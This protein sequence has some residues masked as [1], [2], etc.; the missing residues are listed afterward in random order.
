MDPNFRVGS[1]P[2][3]THFT[4]RDVDPPSA[5]Y[6]LR[7]DQLLIQAVSIDTGFAH[8]VT[9]NYRFLRVPEVQGG[10][11][12]DLAQ[13]GAARSV[14][15]YGIIDTGADVLVLPV[16]VSQA[17]FTRTLG[18]G[19]MLAVG[20]VA[21]GV[22]ER[23]MIFVRAVIQ[24]GGVAT[25]N[26]TQT[27][28]S[29]YVVPP[30]PASWPG[31]RQ[32][33]P[34]EGPGWLHLVQVANPG[35]GA[36]WSMAVPFNIRRRILSVNAQLATSATVANRIVEMRHLSGLNI[37]ANGTPNQVVVA[38]ATVQVTGTSSLLTAV[39][40]VADVLVS[41]PS[42]LILQPGQSFNS[43]TINIQA[44]DQWSNIFLWVED[45]VAGL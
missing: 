26:A 20:A 23:G 30:T 29:D 3:F 6:V 14:I 9:F 41:I 22:V 5:L 31:G 42:T 11:P 8:N 12:S 35:A 21:T 39:A 45:W 16:G 10:Q 37:L 2:A 25:L 4:F 28:F 7:D 27:L 38:G 44:G 24:R 1:V 40:N 32:Q 36:D 33:A 13:P 18:E 43:N 34:L 15:D 19:Y 17:L